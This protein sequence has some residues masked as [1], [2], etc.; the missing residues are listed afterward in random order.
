MLY[1][2]ILYTSEMIECIKQKPAWSRARVTIY[3]Y[4]YVNI[5]MNT[6]K[7]TFLFNTYH[8]NI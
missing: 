6:M 8:R 7:H 2:N 5:H 3:T 4:L 1:N